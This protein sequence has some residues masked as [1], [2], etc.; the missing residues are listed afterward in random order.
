MTTSKIIMRGF[1]LLAAWVVLFIAPRAKG[2][3][4]FVTDTNDGVGINSLR[5]AIIDANRIGGN[6][7]IIHGQQFGQQFVQRRSNN[8]RI[9]RLTISGVDED[10]A[11]TGDLDITRGNL[12]ISGMSPSVTIDATGLGDRVFQIFKNAHLTLENLVIKGGTAPLND[13]GN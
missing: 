11:Q 12:T 10:N 4:F 7:T 3:V 13:D 6:N 5:G 1:I 9:F 2:L 8:Q